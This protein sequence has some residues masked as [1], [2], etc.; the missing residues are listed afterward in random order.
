VWQNV[1]SPKLLTQLGL[2]LK[3][4]SPVPGA[5]SIRTAK[6]GAD[7]KI[8][9]QTK[10]PLYLKMGDSETKLRCFP[11][12]LENLSMDINICGPFMKAHNIDQIHS[13]GALKFQGKLIPLLTNTSTLIAPIEEIP[14][15]TCYVAES[16]IVEPMCSQIIPIYLP[17][18]VAGK[19]P[20]G[21]GILNG[22]VAFMAT[23]DLHPWNAAMVTAQ[24]DGSIHGGVMNTRPYPIQIRKG[25]E[26]GT[27]RLTANPAIHNLYPWRICAITEAPQVENINETPLVPPASFMTG[28]TTMLNK[29]SRLELESHFSTP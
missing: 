6:E 13:K 14:V 28:K 15:A 20:N 21:D 18:V 24:P 22:T 4:L 12:V 7:L 2:S 1:I 27:F 10:E 29:Q 8:L 19:M 17:A 9:G 5:T 26:Y 16:V 23:T 3:D 11:V 25:T